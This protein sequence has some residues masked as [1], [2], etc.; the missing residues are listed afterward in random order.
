MFG[1]N[2]YNLGDF[3]GSL[4]IFIKKFSEQLILPYIKI[5]LYGLKV[6]SRQPIKLFRYR[7]ISI[8]KHKTRESLNLK[9]EQNMYYS[10]IP[11]HKY[12]YDDANVFII[13][14]R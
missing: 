13:L 7:V 3:L 2:N 6:V 1:C 9:D 4:E 10:I 5:S 12:S 14:F 11:A 8:I